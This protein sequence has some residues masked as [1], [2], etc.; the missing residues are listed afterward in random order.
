MPAL[1]LVVEDERDLAF[2]IQRNL[3]F[4]EYEVEVVHD[5]KAALD[6]GRAC[7]HD[8]IILDLMLPELDGM[9]VLA[10]LRA[11]GV[12]T[13]VL[14][15]TARGRR[16]QSARAPGWSRRLSDEALRTGRDASPR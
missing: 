10:R 8:L 7:E 11:E 12:Q 4:D 14:I 13:P 2:G 1:I 3:E 6:R 9:S 5:G 15:L 16:G